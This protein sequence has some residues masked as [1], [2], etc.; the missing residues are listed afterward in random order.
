MSNGD[1]EFCIKTYDSQ[2]RPGVAA[3][4]HIDFDQYHNLQPGVVVFNRYRIL[5]RLGSGTTGIVY[6]CRDLFK[7]EST[8][9]LKVL[10]KEAAQEPYLVARF[11]NE[12]HALYRISHHNV[13]RGHEFFRNSGCEAFTME[14]VE[15]RELSRLIPP[16]EHLEIEQ[17]VG[18]LMQILTGLAAIHGSHFLHRDLKP[19]N[20]FVSVKGVVKIGDFSTAMSLVPDV[21]A[22]PLGI[23][24]TPEYMSPEAI[25]GE[26][27]DYRTDIF[28]VG[29]VAYQMLTG[30]LPFPY[31]SPEENLRARLKG[32]LPPADRVRPDCPQ[33]LS[34]VIA[35]ALE[36]NPHRRFS[37]AEEMQEALQKVTHDEGLSLVDR[38]FGSL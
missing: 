29:V 8:L 7:V 30:H 10:S 9:A 21:H 19:K 34:K 15:G 1:K 32:K 27:L 37:S 13:I 31:A 33:S 5:R 23:D 26:A 18:I 17:V 35:R 25:M 3:Q 22:E 14:Y 6:S 2:D 16:H 38:L 11:R 36:S 4:M 12:I 28:S 24:G 20:I